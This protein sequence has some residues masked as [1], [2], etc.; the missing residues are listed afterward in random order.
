MP[1][2]PIFWVKTGLDALPNIF[3]MAD[4]MKAAEQTRKLGMKNVELI[5]IQTK[6]EVRRLESTQKGIVG[7]TK[8]T[9]AAS[10]FAATG[11]GSSSN[12]LS[13]MEK[14]FQSQRDWLVMV[15]AS[16]A[17]IAALDADLRA[18]AI[19]ARGKAGALTSAV[20]AIGDIG[21]ELNWWNS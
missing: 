3:A 10:G 17:E 21:S 6:E 20:S 12:F 2:D 8:A 1:L 16:R 9:I 4:S 7:T 13:N 15:G 5:N 18:E 19:G 11:G 14:E